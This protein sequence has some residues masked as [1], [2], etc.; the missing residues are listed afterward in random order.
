MQAV[1]ALRRKLLENSLHPNTVRKYESQLGQY[2]KF[3][4][5][6]P[7]LDLWS[8]E[9]AAFW[10]LHCIEV[11]GLAKNTLKG[12]IPAFAYGVFKYTGRRC[13]TGKENRYSVLSMVSRAI[14]RMADDVQR[15]LAVGKA[16]LTKCFDTLVSTFTPE[17]AIQLWAWW[18]VSYGA[19]LRCSEV[20]RIQW[21]DVIFGEDRT[22]EGLPKSLIITIRALG[23]NTFKT[24]QCSV[25]FKFSAITG[26]GICP[27]KAMWSW[28]QSTLRSYG[29]LG[30][31]VF[32]FQVDAVRKAFQQVAAASLGGLPQQFG[33]HS[34]RAGAATDAEELGW[35]VSQI[36]FMG[37]WR[38]PTVLVYLR[39][40]DKWLHELGVPSR[41][42]TTV[43][44]TL[45]CGLK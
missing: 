20:S 40:G 14:E 36:M 45:S 5:P 26:P 42:G 31:A 1:V 10:I 22:V 27:V 30:E 12:R 16:G 24:H 13:D 7:L 37:R 2:L 35:S 44:P 28:Q 17:S 34:L 43:R 21:K 8:D 23:E 39:Q 41:T 38:S 3:M 33:L 19:M 29:Y 25:E 11:R 9:S 18:I 4:G 6:T 32:S 15:K